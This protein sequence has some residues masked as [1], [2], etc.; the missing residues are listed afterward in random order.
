[1]DST[2]RQSDSRACALIQDTVEFIDC[3]CISSSRSH[4]KHLRE[5]LT[6]KILA[7]LFCLVL[8]ALSCSEGTLGIASMTDCPTK[9]M[10]TLCIR[11][12]EARLS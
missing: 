2:Q 6:L 8:A 11:P 7:P 10:Y 4:S 12:P 9:G 5:L 3:R 1:M